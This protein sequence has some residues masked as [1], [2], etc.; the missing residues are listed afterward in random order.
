MRGWSRAVRSEEGLITRT[1]EEVWIRGSGSSAP[2][3]VL[4][5][6]FSELQATGTL[7]AF[8]Q[9]DS[10]NSSMPRGSENCGNDWEE[11]NAT[12]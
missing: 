11:N 2:L 5:P 3:H 7:E 9:C 6:G 8:L 4:P 1:C 12:H 10:A